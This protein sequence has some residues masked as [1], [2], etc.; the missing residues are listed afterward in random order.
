MNLKKITDEEY[1]NLRTEKKEEIRVS[2]KMSKIQQIFSD[3][4]QRGIERILSFFAKYDDR[5]IDRTIDFEKQI[6]YFS[7][8]ISGMKYTQE[9]IGEFCFQVTEEKIEKIKEMYVLPAISLFIS[10]LINHHYAKTRTEEKYVL[11]FPEIKMKNLCY[12]LSG[13]NV[14]IIGDVSDFV[15]EN[16]QNG[17]VEIDGNAGSDAGVYMHGGTL[18]IHENSGNTCGCYNHGG[19]I[20]VDKNTGTNTGLHMERGIIIVNGTV[21]MRALEINGGEV[22][23]RGNLLYPTEFEKEFKKENWEK[24]LGKRKESVDEI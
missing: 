22:W 10:A 5:E 1:A 14:R 15:C 13:G 8:L 23:E 7:E 4:L 17:T 2:K 24:R 6:H 9:D 16:M 19:K 18:H 3:T 12:G 11:A 20:I 21:E